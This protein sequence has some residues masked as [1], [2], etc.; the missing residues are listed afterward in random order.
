MSLRRVY[1]LTQGMVI[2][3]SG[4]TLVL[5]AATVGAEMCWQRQYDY[6][7]ALRQQRQEL[8]AATA[9]LQRHLS[10][11]PVPG[12]VAQTPGQ[13]VFIQPAPPR[14]PRPV[15]VQPTPFWPLEGY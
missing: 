15:P 4:A 14:P 8:M 5:Y 6:L 1:R 13:T 9:A 3:L 2:G 7:L 12:M 10:Q 11:A